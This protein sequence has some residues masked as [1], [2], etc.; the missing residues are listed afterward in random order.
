L[1]E[2]APA[3]AGWWY[4]PDYIINELNINSAVATPWHDEVVLLRENKPYTITGYAYTGGGRKIIRCEVSVDDGKTWRQANIHRF[5]KP[6]PYGKTWAWVFWDLTVS[7]FEFTQCKELLVRA[8]DSSQN[9]QP[10]MIT[11]N[12]T[13]MMNNSYFRIK[14]H[15]H[16]A[17]NAIGLRFQHP[18]PL[19]PGKLGNKGWREEE[20]TEA[21][22]ASPKV[23]KL[24]ELP[25]APK[26]T[27]EEISQH[28]NEDSCWFVREGR[29]YDA[30]SFLND[31]PGGADSVLLVAGQEATVE[32]DSVHSAEA[33]KQLEDFYIGDVAE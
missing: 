9:G 17:G 22:E 18:A 32:F 16:T 19:Y 3:R 26:Y 28:D 6:N 25:N 2:F 20:S 7:T 1:S 14:I 30:T 27:M 5:E 8:W 33:K 29:V 31:H 24:K 13:G 11:W 23:E 4:K 21:V 15:P 12:L 10:A